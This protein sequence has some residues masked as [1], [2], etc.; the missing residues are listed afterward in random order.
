[1]SSSFSGA[2]LVVGLGGVTNGGKTTMCKA[3]EDLF[4]SNKYHLRVKSLHMDDY[5]HPTD[6]PRHIHLEEFNHHDWDCLEA[7]DTDRFIADV[8]SFRS[9]CDLLLVEGF[10]IFN[11]S[12][13]KH[14]KLFDLGYY[15]DLPYE[16][17]RRRRSSRNYDPPDPEGYFEGHVWQAYV[18][19]KTDALEQNKHLG[20]ELIDTTKE[21]F[22]QVQAKIVS[23]IERS[24]K[25]G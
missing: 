14:S 13:P 16:E 23:D 20:L 2:T 5:F 22:D 19:A 24:L 7:L 25:H 6:D 21:S 11:V 4:S 9:Q 1:M 3:L 18:N 12:S 8:Q 17:C 15:F 10:L